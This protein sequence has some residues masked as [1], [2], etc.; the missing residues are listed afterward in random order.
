MGTRFVY[1]TPPTIYHQNGLEV[2]KRDMPSMVNVRRFLT[3]LIERV[4][5]DRN[6]VDKHRCSAICGQPIQLI[7]GFP[8]CSEVKDPIKIEY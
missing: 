7:L 5:V 1:A 4:M 6:P 8:H 2:A 3:T